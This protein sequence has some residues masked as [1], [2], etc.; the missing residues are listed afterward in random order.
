MALAKYLESHPRV[1][2]VIYPGLPSHSQHELAC[3]Q[4]KGEQEF[5]SNRADLAIQVLAA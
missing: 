3:R 1:I 2:Q 5:N 4:Q